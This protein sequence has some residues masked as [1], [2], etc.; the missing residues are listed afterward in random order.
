MD[1]FWAI[2]DCYRFTLA[3][4]KEKRKSRIY[5]IDRIIGNVYVFWVFFAD[6]S[7]TVHYW[8]DYNFI[9]IHKVC[10]HVTEVWHLFLMLITSPVNTD[11]C[12]YHFYH[13]IEKTVAIICYCAFL[14]HV[15]LV[16]EFF[17][18][19]VSTTWLE[20]FNSYNW[21]NFKWLKVP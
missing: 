3:K 9:C 16:K 11:R 18:L 14:I 21:Q 6:H 13:Y 5:S 8:Y 20:N 1:N 17:V 19:G 15:F 10:F 12:R 7:F 2:T 4:C